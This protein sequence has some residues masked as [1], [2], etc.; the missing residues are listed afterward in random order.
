[1]S[2]QTTPAAPTPAAPAT[3]STPTPA[4]AL[5][6]TLTETLSDKP[7]E[8]AAV[9]AGDLPPAIE[10]IERFF[11]DDAK[12]LFDVFDGAFTTDKLWS[13]F[14]AIGKLGP[15]I[16][17]VLHGDFSATLSES[18]KVHEFSHLAAA[19]PSKSRTVD[20]NLTSL[21]HHMRDA[22]VGPALVGEDPR[23]MMTMNP[24][25]AGALAAVL[26]DVVSELMKRLGV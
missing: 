6:S 26:K 15:K 11:P 23:P 24:L 2:E 16:D 22:E 7:A 8:P 9:P 18:A 21:G 3:E 10:L 5:E 12:P 4:A 1:M 19:M 17:K 13:A 20:E 14:E 25:L